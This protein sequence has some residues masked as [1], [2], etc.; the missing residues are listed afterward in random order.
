MV[1]VTGPCGCDASSL[2]TNFLRWSGLGN[3]TNAIVAALEN[4]FCFSCSENT[5]VTRLILLLVVMFVLP[6]FLLL[7]RQEKQSGKEI[8]YI[9]S[10]FEVICDCLTEKQ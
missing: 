2:A 4:I 8:P 9:E 3:L 5:L 1:K 10:F 7:H 6:H